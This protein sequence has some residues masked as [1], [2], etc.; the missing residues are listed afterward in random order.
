MQEPSSPSIEALH[1]ISPLLGVL[2][3]KRHPS[4]VIV[5]DDLRLRALREPG[6]LWRPGQHVLHLQS[7]KQGREREGHA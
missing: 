4:Q 2:P 6:G 5:G 1:W 3:G 7:E